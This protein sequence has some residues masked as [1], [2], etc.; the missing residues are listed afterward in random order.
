MSAS[1]KPPPDTV[2]NVRGRINALKLSAQQHAAM[3]AKEDG[4]DL[5]KALV[6]HMKVIESRLKKLQ[7]RLAKAQKSAPKDQPAVAREKP[8]DS[9][10]KAT[11]KA[12]TPK[13][14]QEAGDLL[15]ALSAL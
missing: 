12:P 13:Q 2:A 10:K 6:K 11:E 5:D 1:K 8:R 9:L 4:G 14:E 15:A 3:D 7:G